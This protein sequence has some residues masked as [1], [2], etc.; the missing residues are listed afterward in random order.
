MHLCEQALG[1]ADGALEALQDLGEGVADARLLLELG[2]EAGKDGGVEE[3][4]LQHG[5]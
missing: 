5:G 1:G 2:L 3:G 4:L